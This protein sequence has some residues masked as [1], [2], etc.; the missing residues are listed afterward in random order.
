MGDDPRRRL[1]RTGGLP[2]SPC[3]TTSAPCCLQDTAS[4]GTLES[5]RGFLI[6]NLPCRGGTAGSAGPRSQGAIDREADRR[7]AHIRERL[8]ERHFF[9]NESAAVLDETLAAVNLAERGGAVTEMVSGYSA[10][11]LGIG[12]SGLRAP[13]RFY[14]KRAIS[15][16]ERFEPAAEVSPRLSAG[17]GFRIRH[18]RLGFRK[19]VRDAL[20]LDVSPARRSR[21]RADPAD[22]SDFGSRAPRRT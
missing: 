11:G 5:G 6:R 4:R 7:A 18:R 20:A 22:G 10:L 1:Q 12:M 16:T 14:Q 19:A 17:G 3:L 2:A 8:A 13:G 9:R 15:L 21:P